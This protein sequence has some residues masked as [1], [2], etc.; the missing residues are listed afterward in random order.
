MIPF[1]DKEEQ[2]FL[3]KICFL[4]FLAYA[5]VSRMVKAHILFFMALTLFARILRDIRY[6]LKY[7][8]KVL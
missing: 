2:I 5:K 7:E 8:Q 6:L 4:I 1:S 3:I